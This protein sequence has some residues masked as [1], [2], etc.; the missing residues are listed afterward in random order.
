MGVKVM[1]VDVGGVLLTNGWDSALRREVASHFSIDPEEL[2]QR[3]E[4]IFDDFECGRCSFDEYLHHVIF[5]KERSFSMQQLK[6]Y[7]YAGFKPYPEAIQRIKNLK[8]RHHAKL[9]LLSNE[10]REL[11]EFRFNKFNFHDFVDYFIVSSF[12]GLRK[13]DPRIYK[14]ALDLCQENPKNV[15]YID[16]R[17]KYFPMAKTLGLRTVCL[18]SAEKYALAV[19]N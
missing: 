3:H 11:A 7:V 2:Q 17:E 5:F 9:A 13:P 16:D 6:E 18:K 4:M 19:R 1:L 8:A 12:V 15:L 10:G 14:L